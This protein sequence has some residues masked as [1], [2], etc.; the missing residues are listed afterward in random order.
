MEYARKFTL[1]PA[2]TAIPA[3]QP[4]PAAKP[5]PYSTAI[6]NLDDV[7]S[8]VLASN[9]DDATKA[10][11]YQQSLRRYL[12][13]QRPR[14]TDAPLTTNNAANTAN[15]T[16]TTTPTSTAA[17]TPHDDT[18]VDSG[19]LTPV[20]QSIIDA[21]PEQYKFY[22]TKIAK[23]IQEHKDVLGWTK[24]GQLIHKNKVVP[25][26]SLPQLMAELADPAKLKLLI[27]KKKAFRPTGWNE[28]VAGLN[29][30]NYLPPNFPKSLMH[31]KKPRK[32]IK[33]ENTSPKILRSRPKNTGIVF[34]NWLPYK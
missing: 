15:I 1:M 21:V 20:E 32:S 25:F 12:A 30:M 8:N 23:K 28:L 3:H 34:K 27:K 4:L 6:S 19:D 9:L 29:E 33:K 24:G 22:A 11:L 13:L 17:V 18:I 26:S 16:T 7:M 2:D 31:N 14:G 10:Q 5:K